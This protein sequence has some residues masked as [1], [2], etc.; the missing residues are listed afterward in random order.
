MIN[1]TKCKIYRYYNDNFKIGYLFE[2]FTC[3]YMPNICERAYVYF[4]NLCK[5]CEVRNEEKGS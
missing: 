3:G 1:L 2:I 5:E 4:P